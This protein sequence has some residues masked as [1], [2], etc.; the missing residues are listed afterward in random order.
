MKKTRNFIAA[1]TIFAISSISAF[2]AEA[3]WESSSPSGKDN[4]WERDSGFFEIVDSPKTWS[5]S[6]GPFAG[7]TSDEYVK[8]NTDTRVNIFGGQF[9]LNKTIA[10]KRNN[11]PIGLDV[12]L[13]T[14]LDVGYAEWDEYNYYYDYYDGI[15]YVDSYEYELSQWD[16]MIGPQIG[17]RLLP[18]NALSIGFGIQGG[19]DVRS[20]EY[21]EKYKSYNYSHETEYSESKAGTFFGV[22][23]D[24]R[25][26]LSE[27]W[28]LY[29]TYRYVGT[30]VKFEEY[31]FKDAEEIGYH[32]ISL[33]AVFS[34]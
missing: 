4:A 3:D 20:C 14:V 6:F 26:R 9:L 1:S 15:Y 31:F 28:A 23:A 22:Y 17:L 19:L 24:L 27:C 8:G 30:N 11:A 32:M 10:A 34:W 13:F 21:T 7:L 5:I 33:G 2:S 25:I 12:G 29:G 16:F 18:N